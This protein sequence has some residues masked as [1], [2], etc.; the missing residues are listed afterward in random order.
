MTESFENFEEAIS[1]TTTI[2]QQAEQ[3]ALD[4]WDARSVNAYLEIVQ[5][6]HDVESGAQADLLAEYWAD[7][8]RVGSPLFTHMFLT[9][10]HRASRTAADRLAMLYRLL[11]FELDENNFVQ[12]HRLG[13]SALDGMYQLVLDDVDDFANYLVFVDV[14]AA[15]MRLKYRVWQGMKGRFAKSDRLTD[16]FDNQLRYYLGKPVVDFVRAQGW[17]Q[18]DYETAILTLTGNYVQYPDARLH[19]RGVVGRQNMKVVTPDYHVEMIFDDDGQ[20]V[21]MWSALENHDMVELDGSVRY[22][23]NPD[24]YTPEE[25]QQI[26]NTESANFASRGGLVHQALDVAPANRHAGLEPALRNEAKLA[27]D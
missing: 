14:I 6:I 20:A 21:S 4:G 15:T 5:D 8:H 18:D 24:H 7:A 27:F 13:E 25:L 19:N 16:I 17:Q 12:A 10:F 11:G 2:Q 22:D 23:S 9:G 1:V 3:L 26:A